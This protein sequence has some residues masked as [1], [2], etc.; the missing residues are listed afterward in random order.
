MNIEEKTFYR[1]WMSLK[2]FMKLIALLIRKMEFRE[3]QK[4]QRLPFWYNV[5]QIGLS[6]LDT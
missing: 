2:N 3:I 5:A 6:E 4:L 1:R